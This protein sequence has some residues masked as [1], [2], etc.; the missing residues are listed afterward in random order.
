MI[1]NF[2]KFK[3][4]ERSQVEKIHIAPN[5]MDLERKNNNQTPYIVS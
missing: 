2:L 1:E 4:A 3:K 5:R